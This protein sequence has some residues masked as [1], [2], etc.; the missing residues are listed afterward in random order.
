MCGVY[1]PRDTLVTPWS[2]LRLSALLPEVLELIRNM[3]ILFFSLS[4]FLS[5]YISPRAIGKAQY[6][7]VRVRGSNT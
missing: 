6:I 4:F 7:H 3:I 2:C 5:F 1:S